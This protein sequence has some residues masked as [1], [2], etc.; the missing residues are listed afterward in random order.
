MKAFIVL[1]S[2]VLAAQANALGT[3]VNCSTNE[4]SSLAIDMKKKTVKLKA[5]SGTKKDMKITGQDLMILE[6]MPPQYQ[7]KLKLDDGRGLSLTF[8]SQST[9]G[10]G[11][12]IRVDGTYSPDFKCVSV[13]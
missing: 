10:D 11:N 4:G 5:L 8:P 3:K 9:T 13:K 12:W 6:S 7:Y 2:L 1:A